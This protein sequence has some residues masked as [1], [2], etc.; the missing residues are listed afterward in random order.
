MFDLQ[1]DFLTDPHT[2]LERL[3]VGI[4]NGT[5]IF[6]PSEI[7]KRHQSRDFSDFVKAG[8]VKVIYE[9]ALKQVRKIENT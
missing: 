4:A 2:N 6:E 1:K 8:L 7:H 5:Y 9:R 3:H